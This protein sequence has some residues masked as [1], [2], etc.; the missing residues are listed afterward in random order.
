MITNSQE[1]IELVTNQE[2]DKDLYYKDTETFINIR[3]KHY[4]EIEELLEDKFFNKKLRYKDDDF[5][6]KPFLIHQFKDFILNINE[7][8]IYNKSRILKNIEF[9]DIRF[10]LKDIYCPKIIINNIDYESF[11]VDIGMFYYIIGHNQMFNNYQQKQK[12]IK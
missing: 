5:F 6:S 10:R 1:L 8:G 12:D 2:S 3:N 9:P 7:F 4:Q 11:K